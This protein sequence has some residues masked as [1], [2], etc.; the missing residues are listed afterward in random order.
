MM[1]TPQ[2]DLLDR[3]EA[4]LV[5]TGMAISRFGDLAVNDRSF[6]TDLRDGKRDVRSSTIE[7]VDK[8]MDEQRQEQAA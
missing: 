8:F 7:R 3:V 4:F 1:S 2:Q 6:V 5:E